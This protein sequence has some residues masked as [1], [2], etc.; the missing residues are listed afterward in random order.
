MAETWRDELRRWKKEKLLDYIEMAAKTFW[1]LQNNWMANM[2][3][4]FG[5]DVAIEFDSQVFGRQ[6][7]VA[8][9]RLKKLLNLND[10]MELLVKSHR[11][12]LSSLYV[13]WDV[14]E[15]SDKKVHMVVRHCPLQLRR[16]R[17]G[18][19][20]LPCKPALL[21]TALRRASAINP[22]IKV[23]HVMAPPDPHPEDL[24]CEA[25]YQIQD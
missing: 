7:E 5:N 21:S 22:K 24:W 16:K 20:E 11:L 23:T 19:P 10:D 2:E 8:V 18:E 25:V 15:R 4:R 13:H 17:D 14:A 1:T 12:V 9:L 3:K 6:V